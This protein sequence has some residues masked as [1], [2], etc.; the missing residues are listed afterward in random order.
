MEKGKSQLIGSLILWVWVFGYNN[1]A[2]TQKVKKEVAKKENRSIY[3]F[4]I[5]RLIIRLPVWY[6]GMMVIL[7]RPEEKT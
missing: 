5:S 6:D 7:R 2:E 4:L 1:L 3:Y